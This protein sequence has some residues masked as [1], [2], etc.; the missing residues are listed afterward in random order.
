MRT[1]LI[2]SCWLSAGLAVLF[3]ITA[4]AQ[5]PTASGQSHTVK[6]GDTLWDLSRTYLGDP[7]LWP[8]IYRINTDVV[9]DPHWIFPG[10]VLR[11][12]GGEVA[13]APPPALTEPDATSEPQVT[14]IASEPPP[15]AVGATVFASSPFVRRSAMPTRRPLPPE[16]QPAVR[17]GEYYAAPWLD[18]RGGPPGSGRIL[19]PVDILGIAESREPAWLQVH[20]RA[21][22]SLPDGAIATEGDRYLVYR[23]GTEVTG[24]RQVIVP[25]GI[26]R[27]TVAD[28]AD[29]TTVRLVQQFE[30]VRV[31]DRLMPLERAVLPVRAPTTAIDLGIEGRIV[32]VAS[33]VLLPSVQHYV[34]LDVTT[35]DGV[36]LGDMFTIFRPRRALAGHMLPEEEIGLVQI[37]RVNE[38]GAT[39]II[40]DQRHPAI[41]EGVPARLTARMP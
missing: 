5:E 29:A 33:D 9:E 36:R 13:Q 26:V 7:F 4:E 2:R 30:T 15:A 12:P 17:P 10:E 28:N 1:V 16:P 37:V 19:A 18:R 22:I 11:I 3:A 31:D 14:P 6:R 38:R 27:V 23:L 35:L 32:W 8:E 20:D 41:S 25:S 39:G 40:V 21:Y 34:L 24:G